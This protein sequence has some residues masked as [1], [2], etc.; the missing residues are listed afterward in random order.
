M[1]YFRCNVAI[2]S[3]SGSQVFKFINF[4]YICT[5]Y[6]DILLIC[7]FTSFHIRASRTKKRISLYYRGIN[8]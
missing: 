3:N 4:L 8:A 5:I 6:S 1:V 2:I 7:W